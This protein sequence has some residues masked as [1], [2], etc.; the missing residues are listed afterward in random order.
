MQ[1]MNLVQEILKLLPGGDCTGRGGCGFVTCGKCAEAIAAGGPAN[2]CPACDQE[3]VAAILA[4]TGGEA[5]E[6][7]DEKPSIQC[8][9]CAAGKARLKI[10]ATCEDAVKAGFAADE[11]AYGCVGA[12]S[13][14]AACTFGALV[15]E[16][17]NVRVLEDKCNGCGACA[18]ACPQKLVRMVPGEA[19]NFVPCSNHDE[20]GRALH[21]CGYS[22]IGCGDCAEACPEEAIT[23]VDNL[24]VIDYEKCVGCAAC[25]VSC[26]K[27]IIVD[28]F[29]DLTKLKSTTAFIRCQ[30]GWY[31][32]EV[33]AKAG[34]TTCRQA[35]EHDLPGHC[36][37][38]CAGF[39]DCAQVCRFDAIQIIQGSA[40]IDPDKCVGC[41]ACVFTCPQQLPVFVP[42][43]GA[44]MVP[45]ASKDDPETRKQ[46]CWVGCIGCGDCASNCPDGL[47]HLEDGR[48]VITPDSCEDCNICSYVC[49]NNVICGRD[50]PEFTYI[51]ARAMAAQKG[52][53]AK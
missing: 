44:K 24:A 43:K 20:E 30:G 2:L 53:A 28:T 50:L 13:C 29:H 42:Y 11:C 14:V 49:P 27:K 26:R 52:G 19:S 34:I 6:A 15:I 31:N 10:Y 17:G 9:G 18:N 32:H 23:I 12:G 40:K 4:L 33:Y 25:T 16:N 8:S 46:L 51:Q 39:G 21:L 37:Y 47:I 5:V 36:S 48:A 1:P 22:C 41:G 38:G 3:Q 45:C 7:K 35:H